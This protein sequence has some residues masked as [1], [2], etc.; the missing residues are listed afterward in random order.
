VWARR[1]DGCTPN[2][3]LNVQAV[4]M[5]VLGRAAA[6][7]AVALEAAVGTSGGGPQIRALIGDVLGSRSPGMTRIDER[8]E[9][10]VSFVV[11]EHPPVLTPRA[12]V[13]LRRILIDAVEASRAACIAEATDNAA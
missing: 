5:D 2:V 9:A 1:S 10:G 13:V 7:R 4:T 11:P 12:A 8:G 6:I 3:L